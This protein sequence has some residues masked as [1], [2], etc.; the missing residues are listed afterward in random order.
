MASR[1]RSH[2][3]VRHVPRSAKVTRPRALIVVEHPV[4]HFS[5]GFRILQKSEAVDL[6][7]LYW[8]SD[9]RGRMDPDFGMPIT[10][11]VD[12]RSGYAW[13]VVGGSS[14]PR[15]AINAVQH[16]ME[17]SPD[18]IVVFGW[19]SMIARVALCWAVATR[20][21]IVL[22]GDSTW[23]FEASGRHARRY[24]RRWLLRVLMAAAS[25]AISTGGFNREF[26]IGHGMDPRRIAA[27]VC[28]TDVAACAAQPRDR[29][30]RSRG[31]G[32]TGRPVCIGFAGKL[33]G[34]KGVDELL[35]AAGRLARD[36]PWSLRIVGDGPERD[37]LVDLSAEL[38]IADRVEF[39]GFRNTSEMPSEFSRCDIV[40][41]PSTR[42]NRGLVAVEAMASGAAVVVSS[43]TGVWGPGDVLKDGVTGFVY[44]SGDA[45][46]LTHL[47][48]T[49]VRDPSLRTTI[50]LAA[51]ARVQDQ[52]P[53]GF[54]TG[55][56]RAVAMVCG[57]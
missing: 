7:V 48:E 24:A 20:T 46:A 36:I 45:D 57:A 31:E 22:F 38:G 6:S 54:A 47:L 12:L 16:M 43:N 41:M 2:R 26:Y 19:A 52:G 35:R 1:A 9:E 42:E 39:V 53:D 32:G 14:T 8:E 10:W 30:Y 18:V 34:R 13:D 29:T 55:I 11:D 40:V 23:Q 50:G 17:C 4:Q 44:P 3:T 37:R 21:P 25:G 51:A 33:I 28:P 56:E 49:L 5:E 27:G 15:R